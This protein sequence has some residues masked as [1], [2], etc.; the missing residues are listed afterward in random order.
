VTDGDAGKNPTVKER[1]AYKGLL[2]HYRPTSSR[3]DTLHVAVRSVTLQRK[4]RSVEGSYRKF[5]IVGNRGTCFGSRVDIVCH[6][7]EL[8]FD[9]VAQGDVRNN[10]P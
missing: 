8:S 9:I 7:H 2:R 5:S 6:G 1:T 3:I 4:G 10:G